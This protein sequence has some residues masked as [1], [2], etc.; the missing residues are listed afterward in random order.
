MNTQEMVREF[1][2]KFDLPLQDEPNLPSVELREMREDLMIEETLEYYEG[3]ANNDLLNIAQ[4]LADIVYIAYGNALTY[5]IDLD[6]VIREIHRSNMTKLGEDGK[7]VY[8]DDG[9]VLKGPN[10]TPP[11]LERVLFG[12]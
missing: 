7:P 8:R 5:G 12:E 2:E 3:E 9:K 1:H 11:D 10:Y 6:S 4:E